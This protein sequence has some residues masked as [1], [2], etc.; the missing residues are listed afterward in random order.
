VVCYGVL[1]C[2]MVF[3]GVLWC[4]MVFHGVSWCFGAKNMV[5]RPFWGAFSR[6]ILR[7]NSAKSPLQVIFC[8]CIKVVLGVFQWYWGVFYGVL[9]CFRVV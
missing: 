5:L 1:W 7:K 6:P 9:W 8:P 3:Y 4:F 2:F